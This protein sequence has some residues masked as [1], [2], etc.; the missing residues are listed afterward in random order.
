[1]R[2]MWRRS[3]FLIVSLS[4]RGWVRTETHRGLE[5]STMNR[6]ALLLGVPL[7]AGAAPFT[8]HETFDA[9]FDAERF[10][11]PIPNK[12]TEVRDGALWTRGASGGKY[13]PMVYLPVA[14]TDLSIRFRYRHLGPGGWLWFFVDGDDGFGG[15]D[16]MLRVKLLRHAV[17]VQVD[18]HSQ[19][20]NHPQRQQQGRGAD[21]VSGAYRLNEMLPA[22][23]LDLSDTGWRDV[24][25]QFDGRRVT[26]CIEG[27]VTWSQTLER[28]CFHATKRKL[29]WMQNGGVEGIEIDDV[30]VDETNGNVPAWAARNPTGA[31]V[32]V[33]VPA[34]EAARFAHLS[35]NKVVRSPQGSLILACVAGTF[36]GN[37]GGGCPAV[38]RSTD[39]GRT[40]SPPRI[41]REFGPGM[42]YTACGNLALG[43]AED[44]A[45]VLLAMAY[46][47]DEANHIF[48]WRST[49]DGVTWTPTDTATLGPNKTG[50]VFGTLL[51]LGDAG[52]VAVGHYRAGSAPHSRGIWLATSDDH[53]RRWG[54]PRRISEVDA[55]EPVLVPAGERLLAFLRGG[56]GALPGA[57]GR[58]FLAVSDDRGATWTT[59]PS[60]FDAVDP[61]TARLAAPCAVANP[62]L[63]GEI[64]VLTTE[65]AVSPAQN[66]RIWLWRGEAQS[67]KWKRERVLLEFPRIAGDPHTD[68]GY[69]WLVADGDEAWQLY[70]YHGL[71]KG[72]SPIWVTDVRF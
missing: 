67:L 35:W 3:G 72:P 33:A 40:F 62:R 6:F 60:P 16:H 10:T 69:P 56:K 34:P 14:G 20:P 49:D 1:M 32:R 65:R 8:L 15:T 59:T 17:H 38:A 45:L 2:L 5:R 47:G 23:Q 9:G 31:A 36:H 48:G 68:L 43:T 4:R 54:E 71:K 21:P 30:R 39:N 42:D 44:G 19:D 66:S 61:A 27:G 24:H 50:S 26:I 51:P 28:P 52:L 25:L 12:N 63:P 37:H 13:P 41:L 64:F 70:F 18:S 57:E 22:E 29:L 58:Q 7:L 11:T 55:V 53:G 46:T